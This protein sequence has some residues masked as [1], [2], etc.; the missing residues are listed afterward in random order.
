MTKKLECCRCHKYM[1][2]VRDA[3]LRTG[4]H[5]M[6]DPCKTTVDAM[7]RKYEL[8]LACEKMPKYNNAFDDLFGGK[9]R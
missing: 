9:F 1:G 3:S 6:C 4:M 8:M 7:L 2:E 5:V